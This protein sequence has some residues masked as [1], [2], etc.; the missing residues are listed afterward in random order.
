MALVGILEAWAVVGPLAGACIGFIFR[1]R[2]KTET[3]KLP[4][5][6]IV[7]VVLPAVVPR[8]HPRGGPIPVRHFMFT[9]EGTDTGEMIPDGADPTMAAMERSQA[10][11]AH[12]GARRV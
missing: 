11:G 2:K 9:L 1:P 4:T 8:M 5:A 7:P 10:T 12:Y 3:A 6:E